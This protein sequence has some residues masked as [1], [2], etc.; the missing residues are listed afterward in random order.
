MAESPTS[1]RTTILLRKSSIPLTSI[2]PMLFKGYFLA[3]T[4]AIIA[5]LAD[6]L[7]VFL[8]AVPFTS[9]EIFMELLVASFGSMAILGIMILGLVALFVWKRRLPNLP[10]SPDTIA[11]VASY[12]ADSRMLDDFEG[13]EYLDNRQLFNQI[14]GLGK[15]YVYGKWLGSDGQSRY[16]IDEDSQLVY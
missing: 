12:V 1:P 13:C 15:R 10:R 14:A 16:H 4:M 11:G 6:V 8:G 3:T 5:V 9:G 7:I 2:F